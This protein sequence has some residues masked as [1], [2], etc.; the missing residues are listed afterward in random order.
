M[1]EKILHFVLTTDKPLEV[2][3]RFHPGGK[4]VLNRTEWRG[5]EPRSCAVKS[6]K[7]EGFPADYKGPVKINVEVA[8]RP[9][10]C[11]NYV[12]D[13]RYDGWTVTPL[14]QKNDGTLLDG[15]GKELEDGQSPVRLEY[16]IHKDVDFNEIDFGE[17]ISEVEAEGIK[18]VAH[19]DVMREISG[20]SR[21]SAGG[22]VGFTAPRRSRPDTKIIL[23][24]Q[25]AFVGRDGFGG[26]VINICNSTPHL[27]HVL[28]TSLTSLMQDYLEGRAMVKSVE[29][30]DCVFV[31]LSDSLVD[32]TPNEE[33][34]DSWFDVLNMY[35][36]LTFLD[37]LA[38]KLMA[39]YEVDISVVDGGKGGLLLRRPRKQ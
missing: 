19:D 7:G 10:G 36:P 14:D 9:K 17:F 11:I 20:A 12:G 3:S 32:C 8:Y 26:K 1:K 4:V 13:T 5:K 28:L 30:P 15:K 34:L 27:D 21:I 35:T 25:P 22:S 2:Y 29:T 33:G 31:E 38:Q 16:E 37:E 18:H 24:N 23:T 39:I 6:V